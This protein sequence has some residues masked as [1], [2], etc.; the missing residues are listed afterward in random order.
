MNSLVSDKRTTETTK[1]EWS[2]LAKRMLQLFKICE[3]SM[4]TD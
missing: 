1:K 3:K 4:Q 2:K